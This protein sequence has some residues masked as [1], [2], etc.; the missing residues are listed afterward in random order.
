METEDSIDKIEV[1][2]DMD[3]IIE[4]KILKLMQEHIKIL[5]DRVVEESTGITIEMK[6]IVEIRIG[7]CLEKD[8]SLE[9][10]IIEEMIGVKVT[11][12][13][14]QD[15]QQ[16]QIEIEWGV[17]NMGNMTIL[18][19]TALHLGKKGNYNNSSKCLT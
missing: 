10:L 5:K 2:Q 3:K 7:T 17:T 6:V 13:P 16:V 12:G 14:D 15:Q 9:I 11:V 4:V 19:K 1:D 8:H 18:Q